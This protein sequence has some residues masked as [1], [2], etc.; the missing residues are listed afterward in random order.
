MSAGTESCTAFAGDGS[1]LTGTPGGSVFIGS[2]AVA[3]TFSATPTFS[4]ADVTAKSPLVIS[5][6]VMTANVSAVTFT[7]VTAGARFGI[8]WLQAASGGPYTVTY[9][10]SISSTATPCPISSIASA[11]TEHFFRV[12]A[13]N[14]TITVDGCSSSDP[15][16][17]LS[18]P[19]PE[20]SG[21]TGANNTVGAAGHYLRS[22]GSHYMD[23]AIQAGDVTPTLAATATALAAAPT[24]CSGST[25]MATGIAASGNANCAAIP[26]ASPFL[27]GATTLRLYENWATS[28]SST[29]F[30][31]LDWTRQAVASGTSAV[32]YNFAAGALGPNA[33]LQSA[34][35]GTANSGAILYTPATAVFVLSHN[36]TLQ[37]EFL[38]GTTAYTQGNVGFQRTAATL[39]QAHGVWL[40]LYNTGAGAVNFM[41]VLAN[42]ADGTACVNASTC[43]IVDSGLAADTAKHTGSISYD[44]TTITFKIDG[45]Y[46]KTFCAS[47]CDGPLTYFDNT[48]GMY[49]TVAGGAI[50]GGSSTTTFRVGQLQLD[51]TR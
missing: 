28:P 16:V 22:N 40:Q 39:P 11:W 37:F 3:P 24:Q 21:G 45:A 33:Q 30:G 20:S 43:S 5:P 18:T 17:A 27:S 26:L 2:T 6:T 9:G 13:D 14:S 7:N 10:A 51:Y 36:F 47:L 23:S 25:P 1:G 42:G 46:T 41:Y 38:A 15:V 50:T 19:L 48:N 49:L 12:E 4:L 34:S 35:G 8:V 31:T 29:V 32:N 44:G